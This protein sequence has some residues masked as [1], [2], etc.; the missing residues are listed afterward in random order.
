MLNSQPITN[1]Q[2][3]MIKTITSLGYRHSAWQVFSDFVEMSAIAISNSVD[4]VH[5]SARESRYLE[6]IN[7]YNKEEQQEFPKLF[8]YLVNALEDCLSLEG[9]PVDLL[10]QIFHELELHNKWKGQYFTP[11][12]VCEAMGMM[13]LGDHDQKAIKE[14]GFLT[15]GEPACGSGAM[16]L[17]FAKAMKSKGF[18]APRW[19]LQLKIST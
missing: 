2:K 13:S 1:Y 15:V 10:G 12:P 11:V 6:I 5:Q 16:V 18:I 4:F 3:E 8:G 7:T 19:L 14:E 17:G 9:G